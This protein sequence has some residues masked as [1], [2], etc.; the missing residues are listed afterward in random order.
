MTSEKAILYVNM[1][2]ILAKNRPKAMVVE[3]KNEK[4]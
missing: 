4:S 3:N 2:K 1:G